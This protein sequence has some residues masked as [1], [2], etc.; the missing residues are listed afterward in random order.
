ME[1]AE[2]KR[3]SGRPRRRWEN[4]IKTDLR[5]MGYDAGKWTLFKIGTDSEFM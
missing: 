4:R 3:P 5:V 2:G 1:R